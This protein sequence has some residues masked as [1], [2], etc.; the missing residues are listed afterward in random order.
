MNKILLFLLALTFSISGFAQSIC[1]LEKERG[2]IEGMSGIYHPTQAFGPSYS[3]IP[4]TS[5][6]T[7]SVEDTIVTEV[8]RVKIEDEYYYKNYISEWNKKTKEM[9]SSWK[10]WYEG[11]KT[12]KKTSHKDT[13]ICEKIIKKGIADKKNGVNYISA[14]KYYGCYAKGL[15]IA[16]I[17]IQKEIEEKQKI[18]NE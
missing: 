11:Y 14:E 8:D 9:S 16:S 10:C 13:S 12:G 17:Q 15:S 6:S 2:I 5:I 7:Y 4:I 3:G 1:E 18:D